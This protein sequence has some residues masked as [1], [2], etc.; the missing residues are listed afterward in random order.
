MNGGSYT[1]LSRSS[2]P[3][4]PIA[5]RVSLP[6]SDHSTPEL[7]FSARGSATVRLR[8]QWVWQR[9]NDPCNWALFFD[10]L[11]SVTRSDADIDE[12]I[13]SVSNVACPMRLTVRE[14]PMH[15]AWQSVAEAQMRFSGEIILEPLEWQTRLTVQVHYV[16]GDP[17][18]IRLL[19]TLESQLQRDV[20]RMAQMLERS[21]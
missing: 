6:S 2:K 13:W 5:A 20:T 1:K 3:L 9:L 18:L 14:P 10:H 8:P 15:L 7:T 17:R 11:T 21:L 16:T 19:Q 4:H 12:Y